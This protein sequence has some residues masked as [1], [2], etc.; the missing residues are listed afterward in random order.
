MP[1]S[2]S[3]PPLPLPPSATATLAPARAATCSRPRILAIHVRLGQPLL[4]LPLAALLGR[5]AD[6]HPLHRWERHANCVQLA[7][8]GSRGCR[9]Y[10]CAC[11]V[12]GFASKDRGKEH[13]IGSGEQLRLGLRHVG[14]SLWLLSLDARDPGEI[15]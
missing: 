15:G 4:P 7:I 5:L 14:N 10:C 12:S 1:L 2:S 9:E 6:R 13:R 11:S 8:G 3:L